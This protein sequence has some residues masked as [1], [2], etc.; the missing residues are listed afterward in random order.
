[1]MANQTPR[2]ILLAAA[3]LIEA[4][5]LNKDP[6]CHAASISKS[7]LSSYYVGVDPLDERAQRFSAFGAIVRIAGSVGAG[8]D[9]YTLLTKYLNIDSDDLLSRW[10]DHP[11]RTADEVIAAMRGAAQ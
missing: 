8:V 10:N 4:S 6:H 3:D 9:A 11:D 5:G 7:F 1:M 2:E